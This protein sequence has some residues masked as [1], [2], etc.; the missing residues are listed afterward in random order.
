MAIDLDQLKAELLLTSGEYFT[1]NPELIDNA[2]QN[3]IDTYSYLS[4]LEKAEALTVLGT[5]TQYDLPDDFREV[6]AVY[7]YYGLYT[8]LYQA[9]F[10]EW[11]GTSYYQTNRTDIQY[12]VDVLMSKIEYYQ[13]VDVQPIIRNWKIETDADPYGAAD[14]KHIR[15]TFT[16][17]PYSDVSQTYV[18]H[19]Y[20]FYS[21]Q[22]IPD[23]HYQY[24]YKLASSFLMEKQALAMSK[25][26][27][28]A[29]PTVTATYV[30]P[31][32]LMQLAKDLR[33]E[34]I[35]SLSNYVPERG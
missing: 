30:N 28:T 22:T 26:I 2:I 29:G 6:I 8:A 15:F 14:R 27:N 4:P 18:L 9:G 16:A 17:D 23:Y 1:A 3:A 25:I 35:N 32:T 24:L 31:Q 11:D 10:I 33:A 12:Y 21:S 20:G 34:V 7:Q 5:T 13:M 19:Y